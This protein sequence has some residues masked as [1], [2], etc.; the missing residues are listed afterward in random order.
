MP[1]QQLWLGFQK[2]RLRLQIGSPFNLCL[3]SAQRPDGGMGEKF[4]HAIVAWEPGRR[5]CEVSDRAELGS[6]QAVIFSQIGVLNLT[7]YG[8]A[9]LA[10]SRVRACVAKF[11]CHTVAH[12]RLHPLPK[13]QGTLILPHPAGHGLGIQIGVAIIQIGGPWAVLWC[14]A[15]IRSTFN[16]VP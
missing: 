15:G 5:R 8:G 6:V 9:S 1:N 2:F 7:E 10:V 12:P 3:R 14:C 16:L 4:S 11:R 13:S